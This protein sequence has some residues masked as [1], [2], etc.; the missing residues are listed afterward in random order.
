MLKSIVTFL[1][2]TFVPKSKAVYSYNKDKFS[3]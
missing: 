1:G 2:K 3:N